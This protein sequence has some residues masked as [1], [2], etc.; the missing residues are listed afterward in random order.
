MARSEL[1]P[2]SVEFPWPRAEHSTHTHTRTHRSTRT[3]DKNITRCVH[4]APGERQAEGGQSRSYIW[5]G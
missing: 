3:N 5:M 1:S 2:E 4:G